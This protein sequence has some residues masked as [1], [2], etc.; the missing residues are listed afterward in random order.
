[1]GL[2]R[3]DQFKT[4]TFGGAVI[5]CGILIADTPHTEFWEKPCDNSNYRQTA[6]SGEDIEGQCDRSYEEHGELVKDP[7]NWDYKELPEGDTKSVERG[8]SYTRKVDLM[9]PTQ[10][11]RKAYGVGKK[12]QGWKE[13]R[14]QF[15]QEP[16]KR[17]E[18]LR[19]P[20]SQNCDQ[21][22]EETKGR[23]PDHIYEE[24]RR[25]MVDQCDQDPEV[26]PPQS[27]WSVIRTLNMQKLEIG[28]FW[29]GNLRI[30]AKRNAIPEW[31]LLNSMRT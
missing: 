3:S 17:M 19:R 30:N 12:G 4:F 14:D 8:F 2:Q 28:R 7:R 20:W 10:A 24:Q 25:S 9:S 29:I 1:L 6:W 31:L 27:P 11:Q 26:D 22:M 23:Q 16:W 18:K 5:L 13:I 21:H 15:D